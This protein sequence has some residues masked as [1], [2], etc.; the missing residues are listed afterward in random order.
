MKPHVYPDE[1]YPTYNDNRVANGGAMYGC[2]MSSAYAEHLQECSSDEY[3]EPCE[4]IYDKPEPV[5]EFA[6]IRG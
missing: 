4:L 2:E 1:W 6:I 5:S 3:G